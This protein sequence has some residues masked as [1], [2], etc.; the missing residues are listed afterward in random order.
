MNSQI[1]G[2]QII[3]LTTTDSTN[4]YVAK[5]VNKTKVPFGTVI[6]ADFQT[7]GKG[8]RANLWHSEKCKNLLFSIYFDSSFLTVNTIFYLSKTI[9][10]SLRDF[11]FNITGEYVEIKWPNDILVNQ[12]KIAGILIENQWRKNKIH[13][14]IIGIGLNVNQINFPKNILA[15]SMRA[16]SHREYDLKSLLDVFLKVFNSN[17][18]ILKQKQFENI[19]IQ[20]HNHLF[21]YNKW[22]LYK[23]NGSVFKAKLNSVNNSGLIELNFND[24]QSKSFDFRQITQLV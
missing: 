12:K 8:Q 1:I 13:S 23:S 10:I 6:L 5:L 2:N 15:T 3:S 9:A 22:S 4:N 18:N 21:K 19:D 24:G 17:L 11:I 14:S 7:K 20:Y 16:I